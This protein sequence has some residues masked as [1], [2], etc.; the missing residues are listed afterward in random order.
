ML[1]PTVLRSHGV[2]GCPSREQR[3]L[4]ATWVMTPV[5]RDQLRVD[6]VVGVLEQGP[7]A[8]HLGVCEHGR[9]ARL[10]VLEPVSYALA[11]GRSSRGRHVIR[12]ATPA[13][14][15]CTHPQALARSRPVSP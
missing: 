11:M 10:V 6:G 13:E 5:H 1:G 2:E 15:A 14:T 3:L 8:R 7:G 4:A 9:P 12:N